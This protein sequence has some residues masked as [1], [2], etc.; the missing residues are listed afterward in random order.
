VLPAVCDVAL[1][2]PSLIV[3]RPYKHT[4][5]DTQKR[6]DRPSHVTLTWRLGLHGNDVTLETGSRYWCYGGG[7]NCHISL[8]AVSMMWWLIWVRVTWT[9]STVI[10]DKAY[11]HL[12]SVWGKTRYLKHRK[13]QNLWM[14]NKGRGDKNAICLHFFISAEYMMKL[15]IFHFLR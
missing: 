4:Q 3:N 11:D 12:Q 5:T 6:T 9:V 1:S 10:I 2:T 8:P 14:N 7:D 13:Y 15:W